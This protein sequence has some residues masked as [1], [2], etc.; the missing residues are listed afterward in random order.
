MRV[1]TVSA[2]KVGSL[3]GASK[4][5]RPF[6]MDTCLPVPVHIS[7]TF[8]T[9]PVAFSELDQLPIEETQ[10]VSIPCIMAVEAPSHGL[11]MMQS[12]SGMLFL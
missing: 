3:A 7:V 8:A 5:S 1:M 2:E 6:S 10:S 9:E 4:V 11:R 12:D